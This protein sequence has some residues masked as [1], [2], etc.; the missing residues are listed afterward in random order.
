MIDVCVAIVE[1]SRLSWCQ[2]IHTALYTTVSSNPSVGGGG[3]GI[4]SDHKGNPLD[5]RELQQFAIQIANGM[6]HLEDLDIT[7]RDLATRNILIDDRK[8]LKISDFG[9]SR[10]GVYVTTKSK[11]VPLRWLSIEAIRRSLY[12]SKSDV[13]A[14]GVV[15]WEI[16]TLGRFPYQGMDNHALLSFLLGGGRLKKPENCSDKLYDVMLTCWAEN[17]LQRPSFFDLVQILQEPEQKIY[18]DL[19]ELADNDDVFYETTTTT[20]TTTESTVTTDGSGG[21]GEVE[22]VSEGANK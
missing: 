12:S 17:P 2:L 1:Y 4:A 19:D 7:H 15:L 13:W 18:I 10:N 8:R 5:H 21:G 11:K 22:S 9:L 20:A 3:G 14:F 6:S 16:G